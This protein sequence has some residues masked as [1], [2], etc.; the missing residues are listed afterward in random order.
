ML[1]KGTIGTQYSGS[2][3]GIVA[4]HNRG[5]AY[6]RQRAIPTNPNSIPQQVARS[7]FAI[8]AYDWTNTLSQAS[9]DAWDTYAANVLV[10]NRIGEQVNRTGRAWYMGE[11]I[12]RT[13]YGGANVDTAPTELTRALPIGV[14]WDSCSVDGTSG[15]LT[16]AFTEE[17]WGATDDAFVGIQVG[18]EQTPT[19]N[20]YKAPFRISTTIDGDSTTPITSPATKQIVVA[21]SVSAGNKLPV[22]VRCFLPDGR[23]SIAETGLVSIS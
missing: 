19:R 3:A 8:F 10:T 22:R 17:G 14:D 18:N 7:R 9:R 13:M 20:F 23:S 5:G 12:A 2:L 6:F 1:F 11:N 4:S 16:L 21:G 15:E